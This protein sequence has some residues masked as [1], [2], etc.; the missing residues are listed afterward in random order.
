MAKCIKNVK[1]KEV[2]RVSNAKAQELVKKG[3]EYISKNEYKSALK[4]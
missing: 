1:T 3:W 4:S 2:K